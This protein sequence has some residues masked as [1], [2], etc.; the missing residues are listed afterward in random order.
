MTHHSS[1]LYEESSF[2]RNMAVQGPDPPFVYRTAPFLVGV[3]TD[4][5]LSD[6][7]VFFH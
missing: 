4:V 7:F 5:W 3:E 6:S 2:L 1:A